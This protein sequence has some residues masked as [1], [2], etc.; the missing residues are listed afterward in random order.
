MTAA[1]PRQGNPWPGGGP[2]LGLVL[3]ANLFLLGAFAVPLLM[4]LAASLQ[5]DGAY[6]LSNYVRALAD[7]RSRQALANTLWYA[8]SVTAAAVL[9]GPPVALAMARA[10]PAMQVTALVGMLL[11]MSASI[12]VKSFGWT[13][14]F[15]RNGL[16]NQAMLGIGLID[17]PLRLLFSEGGL[18]IATLG[19]KLPFMVLPIFAVLR[20]LP[21]QLD[22]AAAT[23]GSGP[24][25][26]VF[27]V[28]LP[29]ALP[30]IAVG[31]AIVF[32]QTAASYL[33]PTLLG[34][35]RFATLSKSIVDS[36]LVVQNAAL[37]ST[38]SIL[39]LAIVALV[40][41]LAARIARLADPGR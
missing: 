33:I 36:Y 17:A 11:P 28:T 10:G 32:A 4:L 24:L 39:L 7:D 18:V 8:G 25:G 29:L 12:V 37:G 23:L 15:R 34:G 13:I 30:G 19:M 9:I 35:G 5:S 26:R 14:L 41:W 1:A 27:R 38:L 21:P 31:V 6:S 2:W 22:D 40:A 20:Q 16:L 3:P